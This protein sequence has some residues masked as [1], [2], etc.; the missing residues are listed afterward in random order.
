VLI[1]RILFSDSLPLLMKKSLD[2]NSARHL[3]ISSNIANMDTPGFQAR[4]LDFQEQL[5][6]AVALEGTL[7]VKATHR[8]HFGPSA[9]SLAGLSPLSFETTGEAK[10]NGNNVNVDEE[11]SKLAANQ[12]YYSAVAQMMSKRGDILSSAVSEV[13]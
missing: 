9:G 13:V 12:L 7:P 11:M 8:A 1:D 4:D 10:S 6:Q 2:F 3:L 5:R